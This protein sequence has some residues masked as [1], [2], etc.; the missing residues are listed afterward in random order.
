MYAVSHTKAIII[1][2]QNLMGS[3]STK[4]EQRENHIDLNTKSKFIGDVI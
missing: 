4:I 3:S 1:I 2:K